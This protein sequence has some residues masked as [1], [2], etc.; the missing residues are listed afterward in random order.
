MPQTKE[1]RTYPPCNTGYT[2]KS[3]F[4]SHLDYLT[5]TSKLDSHTVTDFKHLVTELCDLFEQEHQWDD[6]RPIRHGQAYQIHTKT[7]CG[8]VAGYNPPNELKD[9]PGDCIV[10]IP[11]EALASVEREIHLK[12][13]VMIYE[14]GFKAT[15]IDL[16]IDDYEKALSQDIARKLHDQKY[17]KK[18]KTGRKVE[19]LNPKDGWTYSFGSRDSDKYIRIYD[20]EAESKGEINAIRY[21]LECK[22]K[23]AHGI[24]TELYAI[25]AKI[26]GKIPN[27]D[28]I[29]YQFEPKLVSLAIGAIDFREPDE[30]EKYYYKRKRVAEWEQF[31]NDLETAPEFISI[32]RKR[33][34]LADKIHWVDTQVM[35]TLTL[36]YLAEGEK[37][38]TKFIND[39]ID[40]KK[41]KLT[42]YEKTLINQYHRDKKQPTTQAA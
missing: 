15:R 25:A 17:L 18:I 26:D 8:L 14:W 28:L 9:T 20:K 12:V 11:G 27:S 23:L 31:I 35:K 39:G 22:G 10:K 6:T 4:D 24:F 19:N 5:A 3:R 29:Y 38:F 16:A 36:V 37:G 34:A 40:E 1:S 32:P 30:N 13:I 33:P 21:E 41:H 2:C 42:P 7:A